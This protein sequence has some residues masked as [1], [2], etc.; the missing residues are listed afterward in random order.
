M[1]EWPLTNLRTRAPSSCPEHLELTT[2][3]ALPG[4]GDRLHVASTVG[5][6]RVEPHRRDRLVDAFWYKRTVGS[7]PIHEAFMTPAATWPCGR[8]FDG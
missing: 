7:G 1:R 3:R 8:G 4:R 5:T 2:G 6:T